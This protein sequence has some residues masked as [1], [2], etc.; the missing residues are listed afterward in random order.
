MS[1]GV[2]LSIIVTRPAGT[3]GELPA[4]FHT[5]A[6]SCGSIERSRRIG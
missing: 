1:E 2:R 5:Q 3:K 4:I 6:V